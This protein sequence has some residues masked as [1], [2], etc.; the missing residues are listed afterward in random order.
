MA[1]SRA[2]RGQRVTFLKTAKNPKFGDPID[3][4]GHRV[5]VIAN[6]VEHLAPLC[7][8]QLDLVGPG[9]RLSALSLHVVIGEVPELVLKVPR[10]SLTVVLAE[11]GVLQTRVEGEG[12]H[13]ADGLSRH[14]R[15]GTETGV[16]Q[17]R[18]Q[19]RGGAEL[20]EG[21]HLA[22]VG[23]TDDDVEA[24]ESFGVG[25]GFVAGVDDRT[26]QR[27]LESH[28]LFE[29]SARELSWKKGSLSRPASVSAPT[30]PAPMMIWR[31]TKCGTMARTM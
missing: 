9:D 2:S 25:V 14:R 1:R 16:L 22:H 3:P 15:K 27:R 6:A 19:Q 24:A 17:G 10:R 20:D 31:E 30:L 28:D 23:V 26:F 5:E 4:I 21:R 12:P 8:Y 7:E 29:E 18:E 13:G 11:D